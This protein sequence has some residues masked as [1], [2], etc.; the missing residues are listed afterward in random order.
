MNRRLLMMGRYVEHID[1]CPAGNVCGLIG[2][3]QFLLKSGTLTDSENFHPY[4]TMKFSVACRRAN[5][6]RR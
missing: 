1:D 2:I 5:C 4:H 3:D 6:C